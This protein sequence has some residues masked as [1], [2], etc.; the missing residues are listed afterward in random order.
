[1]EISIITL[2]VAELICF[3]IGFL[4]G[5]LFQKFYRKQWNPQI[6]KTIEVK[7]TMVSGKFLREEEDEK[8][9]KNL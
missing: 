4:N 6:Q 7:E 8:W 3:S 2:V 1:M 9:K 5:R